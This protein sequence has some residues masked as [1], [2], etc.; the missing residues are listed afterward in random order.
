[1]DERNDND[2]PDQIQNRSRT[3]DAIEQAVRA[4]GFYEAQRKE[5]LMALESLRQ[6][7]D[8]SRS[9]RPTP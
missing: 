4:I 3:A 8:A 9:K 7:L 5:V 6:A 2:E 1:M